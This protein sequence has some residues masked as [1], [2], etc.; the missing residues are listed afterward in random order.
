MSASSA[1]ARIEARSAPPPRA[2]P[3]PRRSQLGQAELQRR[4]MQAVFAHEVG[5][6]AR[7]VAF[8]GVAQAVEQQ[9]GDD[10]AQ[11]RVAEEFE[12]FVVVGAEASVREGPL[13]KA[14]I[15]ETVADTLLQCGETGIHARRR[16]TGDGQTG[17]SPKARPS[18]IDLRT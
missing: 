2:S 5:A 7:Q 18:S 11:N 12:P 10:Q 14:G 4:A 17:W 1:S 3:S 8:V 6:H 15:G 16:L 13:Q 9:A